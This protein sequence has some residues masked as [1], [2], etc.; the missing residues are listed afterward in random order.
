MNTEIIFKCFVI[1][2]EMVM[3][4]RMKITIYLKKKIIYINRKNIN[5]IQNI[6]FLGKIMNIFI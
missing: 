4:R 6:C 5:F 2:F 3:T 1:E